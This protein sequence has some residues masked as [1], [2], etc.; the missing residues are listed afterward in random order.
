MT[1][2]VVISDGGGVDLSADNEDDDGSAR[3]GVSKIGDVEGEGALGSGVAID[4]GIVG[5]V[6]LIGNDSVLEVE[7]CVPDD[8]GGTEDDLDEREAE[9]DNIEDDGKGGI[10]VDIEESKAE[11]GNI[12]VD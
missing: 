9:D 12:E 4:G 7:V 8:V 2:L 11:D 6:D 3:E 1:G 5:G 10:V